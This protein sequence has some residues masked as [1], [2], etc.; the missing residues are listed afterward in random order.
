LSFTMFKKLFVLVFSSVLLLACSDEQAGAGA[1]G[2]M[3]PA[4]VKV[5]LPEPGDMS[6]SLSV[7]GSLMASESALISAEVTARVEQVVVDDGQSVNK[8][9]TLFKLDSSA[10]SAEL[11]RAKADVKLRSE[12]KKRMQS[13]FEKR[14]SSQYDVDKADAQLDT[15]NANLEFA[16]ARLDKSVITAPFT[17]RVGIRKVNRGDF[18]KEGDALIELVKLNP[19]YV[20]FN[21]P[22]T[23][24]SVIAEGSEVL[25]DVP[26][27]EKRGVK[28]KVV[29]IEPAANAM[30]RS[31]KVRASIDNHELQLRPGL[32]SRVHLP[33]KSAAEVLWLP[34][35]A[36]FLNGDDK[37]VLINNNGKAMRKKVNTVSY[38]QGR[39]AID[40]G[41][42]ATDQVVIAGHHKVPFDGMPLLVTN[43]QEIAADQA[44]GSEQNSAETIEAAE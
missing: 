39:V 37:L 28:A 32:F 40:G 15:A 42:D 43:Q 35:A 36:I 29:A 16:Q 11:K 19:L 21:M 41:L 6:E 14:V 30:T 25:V 3:P 31:I 12:E 27:L 33:L 4:A 5:A 9:D 26:A 24:L 10:L 1:A 17:G 44:A 18:I 23:T 2:Q 13:L 22:E 8:G 34:E 20:D 38:Q 7:V